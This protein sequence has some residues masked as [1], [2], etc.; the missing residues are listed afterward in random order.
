ME[1]AFV[2]KLHFTII[3]IFHCFDAITIH[4]KFDTYK[5]T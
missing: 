2:P 1:K 5:T 3:F 4:D